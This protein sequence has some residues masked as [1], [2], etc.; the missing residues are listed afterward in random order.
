MKKVLLGLLSI[1][2][3]LSFAGCGTTNDKKDNVKLDLT[4][5]ASQL[6]TLTTDEISIQSVMYEEMG[7]FGELS[8]IYDFE[9]QEKLGL[10]SELVKEYIVNYNEET[11]ELL[12]IFRP[13]EGKEEEVKNALNTFMTGINA[14][15]EE[16]NGLLIYVN[17]KDNDLVISKVKETKA[18]VFGMM[19]EVGKDQI[20]DTLNIEESD[21]EEFL[22]KMPMMMVQSNT[23]IIVKPSEGKED[24]VKKAIDDYMKK[25]ED[26][27]STYLPDQ[28]ELVKNRKVEKIGNYLIYI[29]SSENELV[30]NTINNNKVAE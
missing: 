10:N 14:K 16:V 18:P 30:F 22:M 8:Y 27:W 6:D 1:L 23:Y 19:M 13:F 15:L 7:V 24:T 5:I 4:K 12:A 2:A 26:Q 9:F 3:V 29:V 21:V 17:S 11:K 28:Y 25:L 20:K